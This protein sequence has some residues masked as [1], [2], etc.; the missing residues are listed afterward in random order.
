MVELICE[1]SAADLLAS[2]VYR[3]MTGELRLKPIV[4][5]SPLLCVVCDW[6]FMCV[7]DVAF[8]EGTMSGKLTSRLASD[9]QAMVSFFRG[10]VRLA[11]GSEIWHKSIFLEIF[12]KH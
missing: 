7:Q 8:F 9:V 12:S 2:V 10:T 4:T 3:L 5:R 11:L 6:R 1:R